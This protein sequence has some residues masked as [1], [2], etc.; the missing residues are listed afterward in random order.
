M[1]TTTVPILDDLRW[2]GLLHQSTDEP[3]LAAHLAARSRSVY[4][5]FDPTAD[6][7]TIGNLVPLTML[8][9]FQLRGHRPVVVLGG[10]TGR[11][12]DPSGK[13]AERSLRT[14]AEIE[15]N[16]ARQRRI[17][18]ALLDLDGPA[19]AIIVDNHEWFR[20]I[21]F[22]EA[23]RDIGK[24]FSVNQMIQRDSVRDRLAREQGISY[25]EFSYMLLQ[26]YDFLHLFR[27]ENVTVQMAGSD[28]WGNIV[29]GADLVRRV[30][31]HA[32]DGGPLVF[33]LTA[34]LVTRADGGKFG[35][36]EAGA[37][38][39]SADRTSPY[40]FSQ[41]WLNTDD[42]DA[43]RY[44][45]LFTLL[46]HAELEAIAEAHAAAPHERAAQRR[47]AREVTARVHGT[48]AA[49]RAEQAARALFSGDVAE[50]DRDAL[51]DVFADVASSEHSRADLEGE[52][53][54]LVDVL[55]QTTLAKSK[56]EARKHLAGGAIS[57]NGTRVD[58]PERRLTTRHLLHGETICLRRG[59]KT[60]HVTRWS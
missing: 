37:V 21:G 51:R 23:L 1:P 45:K 12:G 10:A 22:I 32:E 28:Q 2:R 6:S 34:P 26:A 33:G 18:E 14:D 24:H 30:E 59:K 47:L 60:W 29:S 8:R 57:V 27:S 20:G 15:A 50:L 11:I 54:S 7:L 55:A 31:G 4:C 52:G 40:A 13:E 44:L 53:A 41:F 38:W 46:D 56:A 42:A 16:L 19:G 43:I 25:T 48:D 17:Y 36:T 3:G 5:G 35:K 49:D 58:D 39:L 9:H